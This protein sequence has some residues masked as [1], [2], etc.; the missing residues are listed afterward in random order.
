MRR[1]ILVLTVVPIV[2]ALATPAGAVPPMERLWFW[3]GNPLVCDA[4]IGSIPAGDLVDAHFGPTTAVGWFTPAGESSPAV[5]FLD[6][7]AVS[8]VYM[9]NAGQTG[10]VGEVLFT[11]EGYWPTRVGLQGTKA[12]C[13]AGFPAVLE[14]YPYPLW[15]ETT[16][17]V[18]FPRSR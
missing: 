17:E 8:E 18:V 16:T 12:T 3:D 9:A 14:E 1:A 11:V 15:V 6:Q 2:L 4:P 13:T 5:L 10:P 7:S